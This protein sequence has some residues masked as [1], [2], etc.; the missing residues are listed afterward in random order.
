MVIVLMLISGTIIYNDKGPQYCYLGESYEGDEDLQACSTLCRT[1]IAHIH[2]QSGN[3]H[4]VEEEN[5]D[6]HMMEMTAYYDHE[7]NN[8]EKECQAYKELGLLMLLVGVAVLTFASLVY[9]AEKVLA[10]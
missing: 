9:F 3:N 2:S 10:S 5:K 6:N 8:D 1:P 4:Y 7:N